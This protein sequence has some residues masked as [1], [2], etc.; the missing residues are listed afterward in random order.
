MKEYRSSI[1]P[2]WQPVIFGAILQRDAVF[3]DICNQGLVLGLPWAL[4]FEEAGISR[5][6]EPDSSE[7]TAAPEASTGETVPTEENT[8]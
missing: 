7:V 6:L 3:E 8:S 5:P 2:Y 1:L 4:D